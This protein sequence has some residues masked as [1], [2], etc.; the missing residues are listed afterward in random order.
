MLP[1]LLTLTA[2]DIPDDLTENFEERIKNYEW[3]FVRFYAPWCAYS[4]ISEPKFNALPPKFQNISFFNY[5]CESNH[6]HC[7]HKLDVRGYPT[8]RLYHRGRIVDNFRPTYPRE[9]DVFEEWL[10]RKMSE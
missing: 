7:K 6:S 2:A 8:F 10:N 4:Q 5:N 1:L 3:A 9:V